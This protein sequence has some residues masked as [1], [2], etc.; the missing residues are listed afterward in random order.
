MTVSGEGGESRRIRIQSESD[1]LS[2]EVNGL[3]RR[4]GVAWVRGAFRPD[5]L[6]ASH[7][8]LAVSSTR[9]DVAGA[10]RAEQKYGRAE[11]K[12]DLTRQKNLPQHSRTP[13]L[14]PTTSPTLDPK[15][16]K[17]Q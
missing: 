1:Y 7:A 11:Q 16:Q 15:I 12:K 3:L 9:V 14:N 6:Q 5:T 10:R 4:F 17:F 13:Q 8:I 2:L